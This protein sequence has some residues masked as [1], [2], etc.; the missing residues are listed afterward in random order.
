MRSIEDFSADVNLLILLQLS[1]PKDLHSIIKASPWHNEIFRKNEERIL[2]AVVKQAIHP[3]VL[4]LARRVCKAANILGVSAYTKDGELGETEND[5]NNLAD[6]KRNRVRLFLEF[7]DGQANETSLRDPSVSIPLSRL[8]NVVDYFITEYSLQTLSKWQHFVDGQKLKKPVGNER[9][10]GHGQNLSKT[11]YGRLQRAFCYFELYRRLFG[12][13]NYLLWRSGD[14]GGVHEQQRSF[15]SRLT[16]SEICELQSVYE[17]LVARLEDTFDNM[18][19]FMI[20]RFEDAAKQDD[21]SLGSY[22]P[23]NSMDLYGLNLFH[24]MHKSDQKAVIAFMVELG[25]PFLRQFLQRS[26]EKQTAIAVE[27]TVK[28]H[29]ESLGVVLEEAGR[30]SRGLDEKQSANY[31]SLMSASVGYLRRGKLPKRLLVGTSDEEE[32]EDYGLRQAG[33]FFW[34]KARLGGGVNYDDVDFR[35]CNSLLPKPRNRQHEKSVTDRL[36]NSEVRHDAFV[37]ALPEDL[38]VDDM[39]AEIKGYEY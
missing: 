29:D 5:E 3:E 11:E 14:W 21:E 18:E 26:I 13:E 38:D 1:S 30:F 33:Y 22:I 39:S 28:Q 27:Y 36:D 2:V 37:N 20:S 35:Q 16:R 9:I 31:D 25:L 12:G 7:G 24:S 32:I 34:D 8:W 4:P 17:Y 19:D 10:S 23:V 6:F 15:V